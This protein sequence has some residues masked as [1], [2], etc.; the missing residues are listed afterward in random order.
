MLDTPF[1]S[2][3]NV[4]ETT[5]VSLT[6]ASFLLCSLASI[7]LG[8][9]VAC[10]YAFRHT[11][12]RNFV[13]TLA[14]LPLIVQAVIMLVNG[15][16]GVGVAVM[17]VF[18]LVRFRSIAGTAKDIVSVFLAMAV[19]LATGMGFIGMAVLFV[20]V[21]AIVN[22]IYMLLPVWRVES[23]PAAKMLT[24]TI[25]ED[26]EFEGIFDDTLDR[27]TS[28]HELTQVKTANMGSL[29]QLQ[30]TLTMNDEANTKAMIDELRTLNG[31]LKIVYGPAPVLK[32]KEEL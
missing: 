7:V 25:P 4:T 2:I 1:T 18:S 3:L 27:Y 21:V 5:A 22:A 28:S 17:G 9:A 31:N 26:M 30:Y 10:I 29:Y 15:N 24:I 16:L 11:Y 14:L 32:A 23:E 20:V 19:G 12:S 13:I 6:P 8:I